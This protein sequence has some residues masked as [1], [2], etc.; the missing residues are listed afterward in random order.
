[1]IVNKGFSFN[2][3]VGEYG[4]TELPHRRDIEK[5]ELGIETTYPGQLKPL[6][7]QNSFEEGSIAYEFAAVDTNS[8][9][10]ILN[11]CSKYGLLSTHRI[12][13]NLSNDY[14]FFN[15]SKTLFSEVVPTSESDKM[16]VSAFC[17]EVLTMRH[18]LGL[19]EALDN[20]NSVTLLTNL[21]LL[22]LSY[23]STSEISSETETEHF[24]YQFYQYIRDYYHT[25]FVPTFDLT[26]FD[27]LLRSFLLRLEDFANLSGTE[28]E[29]F[30]IS[31]H[32]DYKD[33]FHCTWQTYHSILMKLL[34]LVTIYTDESLSEFRFS[35]PITPD[36]L[37]E[38]DITEK[39]LRQA[40]ITCMSDFFNIQTAFITPDL[41]Y[42]NNQLTAD[43]KITTL[44]EAMYMELIVTFAPN[45]QIK[46]CANPTCNSYFDVG[47]GNSR[48]IY[49]SQRCA[50]LM[51]KRKQRERDK[52]K[53]S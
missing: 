6:Y 46:K 40:A 29:A 39:E 45:T 14:I 24:N 21:I 11:F 13:E 43:W 1:M 18:L 25:E 20:H 33:I 42:E 26:T 22:L 32:M 36:L 17:N 9:E 12:C 31:E 3:M 34:S 8:I 5:T 10:E 19:K 7:S 30:E 15:T 2:N 4:I 35:Q 48:K 47:I 23:T 53:R 16:Y 50:L 51:A 52:Q 41:R 44:L 49:C 37:S 27:D 28:Y 38:A